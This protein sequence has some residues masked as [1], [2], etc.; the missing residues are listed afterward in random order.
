MET[1]KLSIEQEITE[2]H[3]S[4]HGDFDTAYD[5]IEAIRPDAIVLDIYLDPLKEE[6]P[7]DTIKDRV[8]EKHFC[9]IV[10]YTARP[11]AE[12]DDFARK[13]SLLKVETKGSAQSDSKVIAHLREFQPIVDALNSVRRDVDRALSRSLR[14]VCGV[15][16]IDTSQSAEKVDLITRISKRRVAASMDDGAGTSALRPWEQ[17][18]YPCIGDDL[19]MGDLLWD[20]TLNKDLSA[21]YFVVVSPSCDM[22]A[23]RPGTLERLLVA[24][25]RSPV[26]FLK[27]ASMAQNK[28]KTD[29]EFAE[30]LARK[31]NND[32]VGGVFCLPELPSVSPMVAV[33]LKQLQ[34]LDHSQIGP[35]LRYKRVASVD[36]PFRERMAWAYVQIAGRPGVPELETIRMAQSLIQKRNEEEAR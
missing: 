25:C 34:L 29:A 1:L 13:H 30:E 19:L 9:P 12:H 10:I 6:R 17:F 23:G 36:S 7:G 16:E 4:T 24:E 22:V 15:V 20:S 35:T 14:D 21:S 3:V 33:H 18:I 8:W 2:V 11:D 27:A 26:S 5:H 31:F 28:K 32:Q